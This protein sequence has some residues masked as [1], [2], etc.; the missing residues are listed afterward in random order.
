[1]FPWRT[2]GGCNSAVDQR[3]VSGRRETWAGPEWDGWDAVSKPSHAR[4]QR[5]YVLDGPS[6]EGVRTEGGCWEIL[7]RPEA[8]SW[9]DVSLAALLVGPSHSRVTIGKGGGPKTRKGWARHVLGAHVLLGFSGCRC[10]WIPV[11]GRVVMR[12]L[13][14]TW[15]CV[16]AGGHGQICRRLP[17]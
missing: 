10:G 13:H 2:V 14:V 9:E 3:D 7:R 5:P 11:G 8:P 1:M 6:C 4:I 12:H 15:N 16:P 17:S